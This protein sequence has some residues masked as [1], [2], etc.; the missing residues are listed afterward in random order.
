MPVQPLFSGLVIDENE[1]PVSVAYVGDTPCY[2]VNDAG[3]YRHIPSEEVDRQVLEFMKQAIE[4]HEDLLTD[5]AARMLGQVDIFSRAMIQSQLKQ[6][7]QRLDD[8]L[9]AGIP[10]ESRAYMGMMGFRVVINVHGEVVRVDQP[11]APAGEE[12]D[13]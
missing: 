1:Q 7:D 9:Q 8:L 5:E 11:A 13:E 3:F 4:G 10:E 2:V 6:I 12:G